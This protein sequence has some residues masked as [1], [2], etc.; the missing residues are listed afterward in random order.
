MAQLVA[1]LV[2]NE[3]VGGSNPPSSTRRIRLEPLPSSMVSV[4]ALLL[5]WAQVRELVLIWKSRWI[6]L[7]FV[8][9]CVVTLR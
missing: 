8:E 4:R 7:G 5:S 6:N 1:R 3:K 2:R 9:R